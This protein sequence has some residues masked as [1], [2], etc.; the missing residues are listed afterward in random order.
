MSKFLNS[1]TK[2]HKDIQKTRATR[3]S[4]SAERAQRNIM[5]KFQ[6]DIDLIEDKL[7]AMEDLSPT[8]TTSLKF[9]ENFDA[10]KWTSEYQ[11]LKMQRALK[12][13]ELRIATETY[14]EWFTSK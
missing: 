2:S 1:L 6:A 14:T 4:K 8:S 5:D 13:V 7:E 11:Q 10:E 12:A 9:V 3:I